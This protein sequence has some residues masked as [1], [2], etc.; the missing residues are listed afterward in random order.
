MD[1]SGVPEHILVGILTDNFID[2]GFVAAVRIDFATEII[3]NDFA[4]TSKQ[5]K[6]TNFAEHIKQVYMVEIP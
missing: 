3:R 1:K 2:Q 5:S 4:I 6:L